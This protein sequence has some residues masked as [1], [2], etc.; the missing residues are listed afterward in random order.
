MI[1]SPETELKAENIYFSSEVSE[2]L[3]WTV[4]YFI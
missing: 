4:K 2:K 3:H 1:S